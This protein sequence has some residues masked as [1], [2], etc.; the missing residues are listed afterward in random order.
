MLLDFNV[1]IPLLCCEFVL[2]TYEC[3]RPNRDFLLAS[4]RTQ[5][6]LTVKNI[7]VIYALPLHGYV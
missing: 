5:T 7:T 4:W 1:T 2:H 6:T 3:Q